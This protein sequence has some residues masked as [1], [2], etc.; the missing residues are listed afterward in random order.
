MLNIEN[1]ETK[2]KT[3]V[4]SP[5]WQEVEAQYRRATHVFLFGNGG[6][7]GVSDHGAIDMSRITDKNV[8]APGSAV[9]ATSIIS[10]TN[11]EDWF[12]N[13][14]EM[15]LRGLDPEKCMVIGLSCSISGQS[16][17][18]TLNALSFSANQNIPSVLIAARKKKSVPDG[19]IAINQDVEFYHTS[20][21]ISL[22]LMYQL[23]E[24]AG[25]ECPSLMKKEESRRS[26]S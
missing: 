19:I 25:F 1:F 17:N 24:S 20:E 22:A 8:I 11:F 21:I 2:L 9:L 13:W 18:A 23:M 3:I 15:R 7:M 6:N 10:D 12:Q 5:E 14:L 16:S 26:E 4:E